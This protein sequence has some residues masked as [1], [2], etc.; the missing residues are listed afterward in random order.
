MKRNAGGVKTA[1]VLLASAAALYAGARLWRGGGRSLRGQVVLITGGSRG[2]GAMLA[3][4]FAE[5][6]CRIAIC[7]RDPSDLER[8]RKNLALRGA[9]VFAVPCDVAVK[10]EIEHVIDDTIVHF[11]RIDVLVNN[12]AVLQV[13]PVERMSIEDFEHAMATNFWGAVYASL[14]VAPHMRAQGGGRIVNIAS[15]GGKIA[16]PHLLPY[17]CAKFALTGFS[18]GLRA[19]L[20]KDRVHVTTIIPGL[21]RTGSWVNV[22]FKGRPEDEYDWFSAAAH[23]RHTALDVRKAAAAIVRAVK[24]GKAEVVLGWQAKALRLAKDLFPSL[25]A[26]ALV[27]VNGRMPPAANVGPGLAFGREVADTRRLET[28]GPITR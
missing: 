18:E 10:S 25:T 24:L 5:E 1:G 11:G 20:S 15:L 23:G 19:E 12:A 26:R 8:T 16:V 3:R 7:A 28:A 27:A 2:L 17:D 21:M 14:A 22:L 9:E 6:G 4:L 13:G